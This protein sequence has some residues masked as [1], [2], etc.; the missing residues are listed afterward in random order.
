[1]SGHLR[2]PSLN[3]QEV[4]YSWATLEQLLELIHSSAS[5]HMSAEVIKHLNHTAIAIL[6]TKKIDPWSSYIMLFTFFL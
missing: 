6:Y 1:M 4:I 2:L 3:V 5:I